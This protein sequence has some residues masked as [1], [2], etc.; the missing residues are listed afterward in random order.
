MIGPKINSYIFDQMSSNDQPSRNSWEIRRHEPALK[1]GA[2]ELTGSWTDVFNTPMELVAMPRRC[3]RSI[4]VGPGSE[5]FRGVMCLQL[6]QSFSSLALPL[7]CVSGSRP[8]CSD[9]LPDW[10]L[11]L[12][13]DYIVYSELYKIAGVT[14][15][16]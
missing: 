2:P 1:L 13:A 15:V 11:L 7:L 16:V 8:R 3:I 14:H 4:G 9:R 12:D 10:E 5:K 6:S